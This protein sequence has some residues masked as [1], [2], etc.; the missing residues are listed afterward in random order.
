MVMKRVKRVGPVGL[1]D[2]V[3]TL[4]FVMMVLGTRAIDS[5]TMMNESVRISAPYVTD[6]L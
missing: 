1:W 6:D 3:L 5:P 4:S 2:I